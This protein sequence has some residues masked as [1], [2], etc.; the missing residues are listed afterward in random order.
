[1]LDLFSI[2]TLSAIDGGGA[3]WPAVGGAGLAGLVG[4]PHC[5]GMCGGFAVA[6]A[7]GRH[8]GTPRLLDSSAWTFGRLTTYAVL[9]AIAG[10][11]GAFVPGPGW[12]G[13][14]LAAAML[15]WFA[16]RLA[17]VV[18]VDTVRIPVFST[19]GARLLRHT[20]LGARLAFGALN[21][22]M[23]CGLVYAALAFPVAVGDPVFGA[24]SMVA[25]GLGTTPA[26]ALAVV[27]LRR[28]TAANVGARRALAFAVL[29]F[30]LGTLAL[31]ADLSA[32]GTWRTTTNA[33]CN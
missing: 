26:L 20:S 7:R 11:V 21:G 18:S 12:V 14:V 8:R 32:P 17:G 29:A 6:S 16:G 15:V 33:E 23:P 4:S 2:A 30:G 31:R 28:I 3:V 1:M 10:S 22:L 25:F 5:V 9:G 13:T 24:L 19:V 27:G